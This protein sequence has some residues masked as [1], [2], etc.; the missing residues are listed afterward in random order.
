MIETAINSKQ[1]VFE[2]EMLFK[3]VPD[4]PAAIWQKSWKRA[5]ASLVN[6]RASFDTVPKSAA[7]FS[8]TN[9]D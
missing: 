9:S 4:S 2:S 8:L 3:N 1:Y 7:S 6:L 5:T